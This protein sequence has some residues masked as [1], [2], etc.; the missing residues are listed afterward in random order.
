MC[1]RKC[2]CVRRCRFRRSSKGVDRVGRA[3]GL[4]RRSA[5]QFGALLIFAEHRYF[6]NSQPF[7]N[8][9]DKASLNWLSTEQALADFAT[10]LHTLKTGALPGVG[11]SANGSAVIG[12]GGECVMLSRE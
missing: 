3:I 10:L 1:G 2:K 7:A 11:P 12:F 6:G 8:T 9:T 4:C 5:P